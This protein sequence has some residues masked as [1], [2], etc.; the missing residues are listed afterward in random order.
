MAS[1]VSGNGD[2]D[3]A[4]SGE[5]G[6][7]IVLSGSPEREVQEEPGRIAP[8]S[9]RAAG[10]PAPTPCLD[11]GQSIEQP[12]RRHDGEDEQH[13]GG[14]PGSERLVLFGV[15]CAATSGDEAEQRPPA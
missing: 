15:E 4:G 3:G 9:R 12:R 5:P 7:L 10:S 1:H 8:G 2:E 13:A 14:M 11:R 6:A